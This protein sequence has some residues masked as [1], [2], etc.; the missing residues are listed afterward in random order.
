[1]CAIFEKRLHFFLARFLVVF[2]HVRIIFLIFVYAHYSYRVVNFI[3]KPNYYFI[4]SFGDLVKSFY[5]WYDKFII[6]PKIM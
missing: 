4:Q 1:M 5:S 2:L 6:K 3:T